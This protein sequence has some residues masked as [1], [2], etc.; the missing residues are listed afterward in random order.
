M[1][2]LTQLAY[3]VDGNFS[4]NNDYLLAVYK[5]KAAKERRQLGISANLLLISH[6]HN[7]ALYSLYL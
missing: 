4:S 6:V 3:F 7:L 1:N 2:N 5:W